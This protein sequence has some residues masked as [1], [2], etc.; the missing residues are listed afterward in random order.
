MSH[1]ANQNSQSSIVNESYIVLEDNEQ[2]DYA[3]GMKRKRDGN[4]ASTAIGMSKY[5]NRLIGK[6]EGCPW[7]VSGKKYSKG[8][9]G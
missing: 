5:R 7:L 6:Y 2:S 8:I 3:K 1:L 4:K 9:V